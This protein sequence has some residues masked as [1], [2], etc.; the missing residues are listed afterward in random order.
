[1]AMVNWR[2][3]ASGGASPTDLAIALCCHCK[4]LWEHYCNPG[5]ITETL[6]WT[7]RTFRIICLM[8]T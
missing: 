2:A 3:T 8:A 7:P 4:L 5:F 6:G 1:M